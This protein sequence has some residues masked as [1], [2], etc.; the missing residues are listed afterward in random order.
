VKSATPVRDSYR[1]QLKKIGIT[2]KD[3][4]RA[5]DVIGGSLKIPARRK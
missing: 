2:G 5:I 4:E 3:A 1:D